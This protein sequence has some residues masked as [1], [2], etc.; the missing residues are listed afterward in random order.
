MTN[1]EE[2]TYCDRNGHT[3]IVLDVALRDVERGYCI[4]CG[5][6]LDYRKTPKETV[7]NDKDKEEDDR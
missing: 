4:K 3:R 6:N 1:P 2:P 5:E 7:T